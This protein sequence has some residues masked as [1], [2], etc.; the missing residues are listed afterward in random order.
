MDEG[1][2]AYPELHYFVSKNPYTGSWKGLNYLIMPTEEQLHIT[3]WYGAFCRE[4]SEIVTETDFPLS[5]EGLAQSREYLWEQ[6]M[7]MVKKAASAGN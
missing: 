7:L 2:F 4:V 1:A 6:Y 3:V 5:A